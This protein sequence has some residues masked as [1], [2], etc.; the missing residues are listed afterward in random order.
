[1]EA[2]HMDRDRKI[3]VIILGLFLLV[4]TYSQ[5]V[6]AQPL[7]L[8]AKQEERPQFQCLSSAAGRFV[9]GQVSDSDKDKFMLDTFTGRLWRIAESGKVG[10][11]L[12]SISYRT[13]NGEY[14]LLPEEVSQ[15]KRK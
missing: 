8:G 5:A 12:M 4:L 1:M 11:Y 14:L 3:I 13:E 9:F 15:E 10:M 2:E 6:L 7:G